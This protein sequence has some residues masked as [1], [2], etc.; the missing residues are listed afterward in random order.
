MTFVSC[1]EHDIGVVLVATT[2]PLTPKPRQFLHG[3]I[4]K[5]RPPDH[6]FHCPFDHASLGCA[7]LHSEH[8]GSASASLPCC[9]PKL[10]RTYVQDDSNQIVRRSKPSQ[11]IWLRTFVTRGLY[12]DSFICRLTL[13][14]QMLDGC[15]VEARVAK[16]NSSE[17]RTPKALIINT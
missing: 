9:I 12:N 5:A 8:T 4:A 15:S 14:V 6:C 7:S 16:I 3:S 17:L 1:L 11:P 2:S 13:D 10:P